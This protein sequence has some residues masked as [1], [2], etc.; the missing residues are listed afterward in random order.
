[1]VFDTEGVLTLDANDYIAEAESAADASDDFADTTEDT[2]DSLFGFDDAGAA[3]G[4][5]IAGVGASMQGA[6]DSSQAW[7]ESLGRT[8]ETMGLTRDETNDLAADLSDATFPMDDAV[9]TMDSLAQQGVDTADEMEALAAASDDIADATGTTAESVADNLG[10][11]VRGLDGDI[12]NLEENQDAFT[13]A[14]RDSNLETED[15]ASVIERSSEDLEEMG[16]ASDE[17]AGLISEYADETGKSGRR[18][19]RDFAS[20]VSDADGD[21]DELIEST[22]LS[23]SSLDDWGS[24]LEANEGITRRHADAANESLSTMDRLRARFDDAMLSA[25]SLLE[26]LDMLA[27]VMMGLGGAAM[28]L[29]AIN[30]SALIPSIT[31]VGAALWGSGIAPII[32]ALTAGVAALGAAWKTN[33]LGIQDITG[34]IVEWLSERISQFVTRLEEWWTESGETLL[35]RTVETYV[36]IS[37]T[38]EDT[39]L[40]IWDELI[41]PI[42]TSILE[43]WG[44]HNDAIFEDALTLWTSLSELIASVLTFLW[45]EVI[46]PT[47]DIINEAWDEHGELITAIIHEAWE[48]IETVVIQ[49][50]DAVLTAINATLSVLNGDWEDAWEEVEAFADRTLER[51]VSLVTDWPIVGTIADRLDDVIREFSNLARDLVGNS[52]VPNMLDDIVREVLSWDIV[53]QFAGQLAGVR[54]Q[55]ESLAQ[56]VVG[57]S[58]IPGMLDA[59]SQTIAN[60]PLGDAAGVAADGVRQEFGEMGEDVVDTTRSALDDAAGEIADF[61]PDI[62]SPSDSDDD[63]QIRD[64]EPDDWGDLHWNEIRGTRDV[65]DEFGDLVE[66]GQIDPD[67]HEFVHPDF[68][69]DDAR[70]FTSEVEEFVRNNV[71]VTADQVLEGLD[72]ELDDFV[73]EEDFPRLSF[74]WFNRHD[75]IDDPAEHDWDRHARMAHGVDGEDLPFIQDGEFIPELAGL[76]TG[77]W[78][79]SDGLAMLHA[80]EQ[81]L[82]ESQ[83]SERGEASFDPDSISDGFDGSSAVDEMIRLLRDL[84]DAVRDDGTMRIREKDIVRSLEQIFDRHGASI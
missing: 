24:E 37:E 77:G 78:V 26:P 34:E 23:E 21:L 8:S 61:D 29:S 65:I 49:Q 14:V 45:E 30:V 15:L 71:D 2:Q 5:A 69:G 47:L 1:M 59:S 76:A 35:E 27:P 22:A 11:A 38:I 9:A 52:I 73:L 20:A 80:N 19:S 51:I 72:A 68:V 41:Q 62:D 57:N 18:A 60:A 75:D 3:A 48:I 50:L 58:I 43:L 4:A 7:R 32:L 63:D 79:G 70:G 13:L 40:H 42:L 67:D 54:D 64:P 39:L 66:E 6:L 82:P 84:R 74:E 36:G 10:P 17:A 31:G 33:F 83:V 44:E 53:E 12:E 81:V 25:G 55:F 16:L 28:V 56:D 46:S